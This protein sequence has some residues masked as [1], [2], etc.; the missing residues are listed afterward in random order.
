MVKFYEHHD[1][2]R[3]MA[4][5]WREDTNFTNRSTRWYGMVNLREPYVYLMA[6]ICLLYREKDF[7][8]FLEAWMPL[9]YTIVI[10]ECNFK[11]GEIISKQL[12]ICVQQAQMS[13]EGET[14]NVSMD[15]YLLDVVCARNVF[16]V[17]NLS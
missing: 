8:N 2:N 4:S 15:S 13:K 12:I 14:T 5:W 9:E 10:V 11:W 3:V 1:T 7:S 17:M 6:L 16:I